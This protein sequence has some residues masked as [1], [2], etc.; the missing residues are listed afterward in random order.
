MEQAMYDKT[1]LSD[2]IDAVQDIRTALDYLVAAQEI[3]K[4]HDVLSDRALQDLQHMASYVRDEVR[5][6]ADHLEYLD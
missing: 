2:A 1:K 4:R 6:R 5:H 3:L